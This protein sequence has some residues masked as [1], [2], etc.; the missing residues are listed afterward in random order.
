MTIS[1]EVRSYIF[2]QLENNFQFDGV[3]VV[4]DIDID[5]F[6]TDEGDRIQLMNDP[7]NG[8]ETVYMDRSTE[9]QRNISIMTRSR[10]GQLAEIQ[11]NDIL[12]ILN[13]PYSFK[14]SSNCYIKSEIVSDTHLAARTDQKDYVYT[15]TIRISYERS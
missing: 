7:S 15:A 2:N 13:Y 8:N 4:T 9:G 12:K 1:E 10:F 11:L 5:G 6:S 14:L 3:D